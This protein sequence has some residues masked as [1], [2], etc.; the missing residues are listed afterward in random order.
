M[1]RDEDDTKP[2][3][4]VA[5]D[6]D[7]LA[8]AKIPPVSMSSLVQMIASQVLVNLGLYPDPVVKKSVVRANLA[9]HHIDTLAMLQEKTQGNL[10]EE[11]RQMLE[12]ILRDVRLMYIQAT[13]T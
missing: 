11:E 10:T 8:N 5:G 2:V 6:D 1:A 13:K 12:H 9:R 3:A 7:P 4:D